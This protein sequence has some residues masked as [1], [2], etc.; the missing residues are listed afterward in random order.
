VTEEKTEEK[1]QENKKYYQLNLTR[2][3]GGKGEK[4]KE[5]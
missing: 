5:R 2:I 3:D 4:K 1:Q